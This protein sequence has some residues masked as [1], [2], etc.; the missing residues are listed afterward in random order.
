MPSSP[1]GGSV[2]PPSVHWP[3]S[4]AVPIPRPASASSSTIPGGTSSTSAGSTCSTSSPLSSRSVVDTIRL[5]SV[6]HGAIPESGGPEPSVLRLRVELEGAGVDAIA[7]PGR[8]RAVVEDVAQVA[9]AAR[10]VHLGAPHEE[11]V[12]L[13]RLDRRLVERLEEARPAAS[14]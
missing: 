2:P 6:A 5:P 13:L 14:R 11:R 9:A 1:S 12:V 7:E 3:G 8:V 10:A 4:P